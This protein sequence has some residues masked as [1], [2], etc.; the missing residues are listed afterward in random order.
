ML[1]I[2]RKT[3][4]KLERYTRDSFLADACIHVTQHHPDF[5]QVYPGDQLK[6]K[7][8]GEIEKARQYH[9]IFGLGVYFRSGTGKTSR[10][11]RLAR[12]SAVAGT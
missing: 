2:S 6:S 10:L 5:L 7:F 1:K 9:A 4:E 12:N 3:M 8:A 11:C